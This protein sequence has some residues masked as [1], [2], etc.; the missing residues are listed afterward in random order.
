MEVG[1]Q[2]VDIGTPEFVCISV[3]TV[4]FVVSICKSRHMLYISLALSLYKWLI[5][6]YTLPIEIIYNSVCIHK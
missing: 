1:K 3:Q 6:Q 4:D 2:M 5:F